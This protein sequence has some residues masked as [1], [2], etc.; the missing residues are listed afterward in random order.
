VSPDQNKLLQLYFVR[1]G[2]TAWSLSG[3]HTG[4]TD[5]PLTARGEDEARELGPRL[6]AIQFARVLTSPRQRARRTCELAELGS[7]AEIEPDLSEWD[8][9]DYEGQRSVD[10]RN[11]RPDWNVFRDGCPGGETPTQISDRA[12]RLIA[13]LRALEGNIALF[14][15]GQF[16]CVL[17]ARWIGLPVIEGQHFALG[18][19]SLSILG[20][21]LRHPEIPVISLW[22]APPALLSGSH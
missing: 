19:A 13:H 5:I 15:H 7:A 18:T 9:G 16:G 14:S 20:H 21:Q 3:Q 22:N 8:Y 1:H 17:A 2:E 11:G 6:R 4:R 10:I 12:D